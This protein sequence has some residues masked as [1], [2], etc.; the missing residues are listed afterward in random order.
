MVTMRSRNIS[1]MKIIDQMHDDLFNLIKNEKLKGYNYI[2]K[3]FSILQN[4]L[5]KINFVSHYITWE[6]IGEKIP[7]EKKELNYILRKV[8]YSKP[9]N[10]NS[11]K[12]IPNEK[13]LKCIKKKFTNNNFE[14][15]MYDNF[16]NKTLENIIDIQLENGYEQIDLPVFSVNYLQDNENKLIL[17]ITLII[18][19]DART[20]KNAYFDFLLF[21]SKQISIAWN[22][23][24][25]HIIL[26]MQERLDSELITD[27]DKDK[28]DIKIS[29]KL[30]SKE[31]ELEKITKIISDE[32]GCHLTCIYLTNLEMDLI[33]V[34]SNIKINKEVKYKK[35][36]KNILSIRS[37]LENKDYRII[38]RER[39]ENFTNEDKLKTIEEETLS[40]AQTLIHSVTGI[41]YKFI[42]VEHWLSVVINIGNEKL[43]L[44]K[45]YKLK[46]ITNL[47]EKN[48]IKTK[49]FS[50][51]ETGLLKVIQ[52]HIFNVI[53]THQLFEEQKEMIL[54]MMR[55][56]SHQVLAPLAALDGHLN[57][58]EKYNMSK[59]D[60]MEKI[61]YISILERIAI[62]HAQNYKTL[63]EI[64]TQKIRINLTTV[65]NFKAKLIGYAINFQPLAKTKGIEIHV[66][67]ST[68]NDIE[69][70]I[71]EQLFK[72]VFI[73]L[74]E[75]AIKYS[76]DS[77]KRKLQGFNAQIPSIENIE[78]ILIT[79]IKRNSNLEILVSNCGIEISPE[80]RTKIFDREYRGRKAMDYH[81]NGSGIGLYLAKKIIELHNGTIVLENTFNKNYITFKIDLPIKSK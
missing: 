65:K 38:G 61:K 63:L 69:I 18:K 45:L 44:I 59:E 29:Y 31:I 4:T 22:Q 30:S 50:E 26:S 19:N 71:D 6:F 1:D 32:F 55:S 14:E 3:F 37:F 81:P 80:E 51:L 72:H 58:L 73:N 77:D 52:K 62:S 5:S 21:F 39:V 70:Q 78:N 7:E 34:A 41:F 12:Q 53:K 8:N 57:N 11:N 23:L 15:L 74:L 49:P 25:E 24:K 17:L 9:E 76:F 79:A 35:S 13:Y 46:G 2:E 20:K 75:N 43:G 66:S 54:E 60:I 56:V 28:D 48:L 42:L 27:K 36:E 47:K 67:D 68:K 64:E 10:Y 33:M 40:S 16:E